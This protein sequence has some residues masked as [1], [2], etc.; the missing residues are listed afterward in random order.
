MNVHIHVKTLFYNYGNFLQQIFPT[1]LGYYIND[2]F[3]FKI[4]YKKIKR[5][6]F[7]LKKNTNSQ[8]HIISD[9]CAADYPEKKNR[10]EI[11]YN[12][13]SIIYNS[14]LTITTSVNETSPI[15]SITAFFYGSSWWERE[16]WDM[17]GIFFINHPDLRRIITDYGFKGHPLRK[18]FPLTGFVEVRYSDVIKR[19]IFDKVSLMQDY[20]IFY[21][22]NNWNT[23]NS[24]HK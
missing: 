3:C 24:L 15:E 8:Y 2:E 20:R 18:D 1:S 14:R 10:F 23:N 5:I 13:L 4:P 12:L 16:I 22:E 6:I 21:F 17:F 19:V 9:I 7:F 11:I